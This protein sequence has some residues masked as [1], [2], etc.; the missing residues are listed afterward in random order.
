MFYLTDTD[1]HPEG[2]GAAERDAGFFGGDREAIDIKT[3]KVVWDH[4]YPFVVSVGIL[5]TAGKLLFT[6]DG[7]QHLVA[8]DP[9]NGHILWHA[10]LPDDVSNGPETYLLDGQQYLVVGAVIRCT[11]LLSNPK[12]T[13]ETGLPGAL[14]QASV[15]LTEI[16]KDI[17]LSQTNRPEA[18]FRHQAFFS[19]RV[20]TAFLR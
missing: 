6:G 17:R 16:E 14:G 7:A 12:L 9:A 8:F 20:L 13:K 4:H 15:G 11:R 3:G 2:W 10:G 19:V 1:P 18:H 5:T